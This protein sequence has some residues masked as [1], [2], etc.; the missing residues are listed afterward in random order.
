MKNKLEVFNK[1]KEFESITSNECS[2]F[3]GTL[4]TYDGGE[5]LSKEFSY[6]LK[7]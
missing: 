7:S 2:C 3:I 5:Y 4:W 1:F 6:Y